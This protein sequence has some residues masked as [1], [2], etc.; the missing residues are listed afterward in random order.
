MSKLESVAAALGLT[1]PS[2]LP[3]ALLKM[4]RVEGETGDVVQH[5]QCSKLRQLI[6][7]EGGWR[8]ALD[9]ASALANAAAR[10][11]VWG[12]HAAGA[13]PAAGG[14]E[15]AADFV[16]AADCVWHMAQVRIS[17]NYCIDGCF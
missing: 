16:L 15:A 8:A 4:L 10:E 1:L 9:R 3:D 6:C 7:G 11:Y 2:P 17:T 12:R 13:A 5:L 14:V